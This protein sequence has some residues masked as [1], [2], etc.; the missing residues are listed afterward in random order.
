[1][2][3]DEARSLI[4]RGVVPGNGD[5]A[6]LGAGVGT[7]TLALAQLLSSSATVYAVERDR[8]ALR[9]LRELESTPATAR[10]RIIAVDG[11]F[12]EEL[13]L[14]PL[15]GVLAANALHFVRRDRQSALLGRLV[16]LVEPGGRLLLVEYD[17]ERGNE[18]VPYPISRSLL[19]RLAADA[20]FGAPEFIA[21]S[22]SL[23]G[24]EIYAAILSP[25]MTATQ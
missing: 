24:G 25:V 3:S 20:G 19:A 15:A 1:M 2:T 5:W 12:T 22:P 7:F 10:A 9:A 8:K 4:E 13:S 17:R 11:D 6:D 23:F 16:T 18:W 21:T 14:P